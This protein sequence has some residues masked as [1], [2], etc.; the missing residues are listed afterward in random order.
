MTN[1]QK[2]A[3]K[4]AT[5]IQWDTDAAFEYAYALLEECNM[6]T[7]A[8]ALKEA[9]DKKMAEYEEMMASEFGKQ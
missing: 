2:Q 4:H 8:A 1:N 7:E 9:H 6:H 5:K 3:A